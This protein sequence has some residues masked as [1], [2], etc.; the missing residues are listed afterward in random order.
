MAARIIEL[1]DAIADFMDSHPY[2]PP[3]FTVQSQILPIIELEETNSP[4]VYVYPSSFAHSPETRGNWR[5]S[6]TV[7]IEL[8]KYLRQNTS[9]EFEMLLGTMEDIGD[10]LEDRVMSGMTMDSFGSTDAGRELFDIEKGK[11]G[12]FFRAAIEATYFEL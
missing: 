8:T 11:G 12:N 1:A 5:R 3:S 2:D 9:D 4:R 7:T 6:Y 10:S